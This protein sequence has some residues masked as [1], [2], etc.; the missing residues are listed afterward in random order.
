MTARL[1]YLDT[2]DHSKFADAAF[3][4]GHANLI[5]VYET[6]GQIADEGYFQFCFSQVIVSELLQVAPAST[7]I[8]KRKAHVLERLCGAR[9]FPN[10]YWL[11]KQE[12]NAALIRRRGAGAIAPCVPHEIVLTGR[13][14]EQEIRD[15]A[16]KPF[17]IFGRIP[18]IFRPLVKLWLRHVSDANLRATISAH[19][20]FQFLQVAH[21]DE[22]MIDWLKQRTTGAD[23]M[24]RIGLA[25]AYPTTLMWEPAVASTLVNLNTA[26]RQFGDQMMGVFETFRN[27]I[28]AHYQKIGVPLPRSVIESQAP[29]FAAGLWI[30][31]A[32]R[33]L[34]NEWPEERAYLLSDEFAQDVAELRF[35]QFFTDV[36]IKVLAEAANVASVRRRFRKSD[37]GDLL[38][39]LYIP[40]CRVMRA[41]GSFA[42]LAREIGVKYGCTIVD[43]VEEL[44]TIL[45]SIH[46]VDSKTV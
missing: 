6:L 24:S 2:Q 46:A 33:T 45:R 10:P 40:H 19:P 16:G 31:V 23:A 14:L 18:F 22:L 26:V 37:G 1:V 29:T 12:L 17:D 27:Q 30:R 28:D 38:H 13:W 11:F 41:D 4:I 39:S 20:M 36:I 44:P 35:T 42:Q 43:K 9:A 8:A 32:R 21:L 15:G 25:L 3:G 7:D 34:P 5:P